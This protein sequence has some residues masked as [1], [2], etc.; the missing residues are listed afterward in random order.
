M[1]VGMLCRIWR[2]GVAGRRPSTE[3]AASRGAGEENSDDLTR[4]RGIGIASQNRLHAAGIKT[5][6]DLARTSPEEVRRILGN[7]ARGAKIEDWIAQ[8]NELAG[9]G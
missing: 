3:S 9:K 2:C 4:I 8:A 1:L 5:Y 7:V 6:A